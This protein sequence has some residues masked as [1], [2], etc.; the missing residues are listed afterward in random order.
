MSLVSIWFLVDTFRE[1]ISIEKD[2]QESCLF[3]S[4]PP[5]QYKP[6]LTVETYDPSE[7]YELWKGILS[8]RISWT[9]TSIK[10]LCNAFFDQFDFDSS[11]DVYYDYIPAWPVGDLIN[12]RIQVLFFYIAIGFI[13]IKYAVCQNR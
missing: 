1:L 8:Y 10:S 9:R 3:S 6:L 12:L 11:N 5:R 13:E 4:I 7:K 2:F